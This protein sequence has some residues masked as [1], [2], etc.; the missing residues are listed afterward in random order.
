MTCHLSITMHN[1]IPEKPS[2]GI[3][4]P[5]HTVVMD[6]FR[7]PFTF[8]P[9]Q[10]DVRKGSHIGLESEAS[11]AATFVGTD[12]EFLVLSKNQFVILA[13]K[14]GTPVTMGS[15]LFPS[16]TSHTVLVAEKEKSY[17]ITVGTVIL[18]YNFNQTPSLNSVTIFMGGNPTVNVYHVAQGAMA[19]SL[20]N[21]NAIWKAISFKGC[22]T[23]EAFKP[24]QN[25]R[26]M[27][28]D[29]RLVM[30]THHRPTL[31]FNKLPNLARKAEQTHESPP[32]KRPKTNS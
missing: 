25:G 15:A 17:P 9:R 22:I 30:T 1:M 20:M 10:C 31:V 5:F 4:I 29:M 19:Q 27:Y 2:Q 23:K 18:A 8:G 14:A 28:S 6:P 12:G 13:P 3:H 32:S 21:F 16:D 7:Q 24:I 26:E 11:V